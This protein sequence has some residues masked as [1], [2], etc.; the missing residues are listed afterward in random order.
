MVSGFA[1]KYQRKLCLLRHCFFNSI[2]S[3]SRH[4][5]ILIDVINNYQKH[6]QDLFGGAEKPTKK[7]FLSVSVDEDKENRNPKKLKPENLKDEPESSGFFEGSLN[8][9]I[10]DSFDR[11]M[12]ERSLE[13]EN[14]KK[15]CDLKNAQI[16][17]VIPQLF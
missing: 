12:K 6:L 5:L 14:L 15:I 17:E 8:K 11:L 2:Y 13:I 4:R 7:R 16:V 10:T 1:V 3:I 9:S